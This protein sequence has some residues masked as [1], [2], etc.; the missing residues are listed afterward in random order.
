MRKQG[1]CMRC[2]AWRLLVLSSSPTAAAGVVG[3]LALVRCTDGPANTKDLL[4]SRS[5]VYYSFTLSLCPGRGSSVLCLSLS[6]QHTPSSAFVQCL[7]IHRGVGERENWPG[8]EKSRA[9]CSR[10][11][12]SV[13]GG[14]VRRGRTAEKPPAGHTPPE[15]AVAHAPPGHSPTRR[16][17]QRGGV[18]IAALLLQG[19]LPT[20][21]PARSSGPSDPPFLTIVSSPRLLS[22]GEPR[23]YGSAPG[24]S[25][26]CLPRPR[27]R[28]G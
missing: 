27:P 9:V 16:A 2:V 19:L 10:L 6:T 5:V 24:R 23:S 17:Y 25:A 21:L 8:K 13:C 3:S 4:V 26:S 20:D 1:Y 22:R 7:V 11:L 14:M 12:G 18:S 28:A 15:G